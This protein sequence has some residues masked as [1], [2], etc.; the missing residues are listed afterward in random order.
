MFNLSQIMT[1]AWARYRNIRERYADWQIKQ[2]YVD[3]SFATALRNAWADAKRRAEK[4]AKELR[5]AT[6]PNAE[7]AVEIRQSIELLS[8]KSLRYDIEPMRRRLEAE[9]EALAA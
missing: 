7:R 2:G 6:G 9:L 8:Y 3:G 5:L 1:A 4:A